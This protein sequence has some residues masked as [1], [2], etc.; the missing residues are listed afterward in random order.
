MERY[1]SLA[2]LGVPSSSSFSSFSS[3]FSSF[4]DDFWGCR[5][6]LAPQFWMKCFC[7]SACLSSSFSSSS[8]SSSSS[9]YFIH[10]LQYWRWCIA[11]LR[12]WTVRWFDC[13]GEEEEEEE[14]EEGVDEDSSSGMDCIQNRYLM[15]RFKK[16][17]WYISFV[18]VPRAVLCILYEFV[19]VLFYHYYF[20][21][22]PVLLF[23]FLLHLLLLYKT[24]GRN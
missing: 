12:C 13:G 16:N 1:W 17:I 9:V 11:R 14:E 10:N 20:F 3:Y 18:K 23:L 7:L 2:Q 15:R 21:F 8:S 22:L 6:T 24:T 4:L 19:F 5:R